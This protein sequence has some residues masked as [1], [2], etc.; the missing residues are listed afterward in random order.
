MFHDTIRDNLLYA[1]PHATD[2]AAAGGDRRRAD[3]RPGRCAARRAGHRRRRPRL[4]ALRR[5][6]G[7]AGDRP[8]AAQGSPEIVILDEATAHLDSESEVAVQGALSRAL[9]GRT[10]LV[11]A[12]RLSTDPQRRPGRRA[13]RGTGRRA[14]HARRAARPRRALR[15]AVPHPVRAARRRRAESSFGLSQRACGAGQTGR[16]ADRRAAARRRSRPRRSAPSRPRAGGPQVGRVTQRSVIRCAPARPAVAL[17]AMAS[18]SAND[19]P[20]NTRSG[21]RVLTSPAIA[22]P[23]EPAD[24]AH[25]SER[26]ASPA[27]RPRTPRPLVAV[28]GSRRR[29]R[30]AA[31]CRRR[32]SRGSRACRNGTAARTGRR[33]CARSRRRAVVAAQR[34]A[35]DDDPGAHTGA[36]HQEHHVGAA[37]GAAADVLGEH[38]QVGVVADHDRDVRRRRARRASRRTRRRA[39]RGWARSRRCRCA[40]RPLP[41]TL[42]P[43]RDRRA[44]EHAAGRSSFAVARRRA[45]PRRPGRWLGATATTCRASSSAAQTDRGAVTCVTSTST[46]TRTA[47]RVR[48]DDVRRSARPGAAAGHRLL[49]SPS[50][51]R[52]ATSAPTVERLRP[53]RA[54]SSARRQPTVAMD[55]AQHQRQVVRPVDRVRP[56]RRHHSPP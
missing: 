2:D 56:G 36:S 22:R 51:T 48:P 24:R 1:R 3:R 45:R 25:R 38:G 37:A 47:R 4:P 21:L 18:T 34:R 39:S 52:S 11:I 13:R 16:R 15:R 41:G 30:P 27:R 31:R 29:P 33:R 43:M 50:S 23:S 32:R 54:V 26:A 49:T 8:A 9:A 40:G 44:G 20:S 14:R 12:H 46:A 55:L 42:T 6:E 5:R 53:S 35:V 28:G 17:G 19:P 10:S 7:A